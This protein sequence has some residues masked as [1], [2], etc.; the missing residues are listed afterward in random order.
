V[1]LLGASSVEEVRAAKS[2]DVRKQ[3]FEDLNEG[4]AAIQRGEYA[5][6]IEKLER[7]AAA[8]LNSFRA[9]YYLGVAYLGDRRYPEAVDALTIAIDLEPNNL[10]AHVSLGDAYLRQGDI[11][12]ASAEYYRALKLRPEY[13]PA[14]DGIGRTAEAQGDEA[15]AISFFHRAISSNKGYPDTYTHLGDLYLRARR[16]DEAISLLMEAV[17]IRPDFGPG[18]NRLALAYSLI[19]LKSEAV[20]TIRRAIALEPGSAEHRATLGLIHLDLDLQSGAEQAFLEALKLDPGL[21]AARRGMA[22]LERRRGN[23]DAAIAMLDALLEDKR[24]EAS[25]RGR[26][27]KQRA[28]L[29]VERDRYARLSDVLAKNTLTPADRRDLAGIYAGRLQWERAADLQAESAPEGIERERLA[30]Y[31]LRAGRNLAAYDLYSELAKQH[32]RADLEVNAGVARAR[33]G[34]SQGAAAAFRRALAIDPEQVRATLY[35]GNALL[36][37]GNRDEA[38]AS[39]KK[40]LEKEIHGET[41]ERVRR[42]LQQIAPDAVPERRLP[43]A[44]PTAP[45]AGQGGTGP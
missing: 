30:Y 10:Q 31:S 40:F 13:A 43:A 42:I 27:E 12:E 5:L 34:D 23:Y 25:I 26:A 6:A 29:V 4:V 2:P 32:P 45:S 18:L 9:N 11:D 16:L 44:S 15:K 22:D 33:L 36:R 38:V 14:L 37:T 39:Y 17:T 41:S 20:A 35:L 21:P 1:V 19:G 28:D 3:S 8:A 7:S 24:T